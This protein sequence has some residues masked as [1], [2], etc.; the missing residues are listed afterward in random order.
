MSGARTEDLHP[1]AMGL[2][3]LP[4]AAALDLLLAQQT[5]ALAAV[6]GALPAIAAGATI[7]AVA[8]RQG[9]RLVYVGAGSSALM[10]HSDAAE[11]PGTFGLPAARI[12]VLM[13][14]GIPDGADMP[15]GTE[16]DVA[17]ARRDGAGIQAGD[18]V[19]AVTAS[20]KTPYP[21]AIAET[22]KARGARVIAIANNPGAAIFDLADAAICLRTPP[23]LIAG[24]TR[25]GA[26]TAQKVALNL[27]S[28]LM[29]IR[30][31]HVHDGMMVNLVADNLKLRR[32]A[33]GIVASIAGVGDVAAA[34]ALGLTGG[35]VK[36]AVLVAQ[37]A[38][39]A[40]ADTTL[41]ATGGNLRHALARGAS[42]AAAISYQ[43]PTKGV[44]K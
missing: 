19:I 13:A 8:V 39:P 20:G 9:G 24:S 25:M 16:D 44:S 12:V 32:R 23:E 42:P 11:L 36:A 37:G 31:G 14:G 7:M 6:S 4:D 17:A 10:A 30:L 22:A 3:I 21:L 18:V 1:A 27:M 33:A 41:A 34:D 43:R 2:D 15:G 26:G 35:N 5:D 40:E 29:A 28:T 38:D